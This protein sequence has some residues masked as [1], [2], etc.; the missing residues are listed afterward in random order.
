TPEPLPSV[1]PIVAARHVDSQ[2]RW[3]ARTAENRSQDDPPIVVRIGRLDV[4]AVQAP[5]A[6]RP[7]PGPRPASGPTLEERLAARDRR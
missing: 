4:R 3:T 1:E 2:Q 5:P 6:P 7:Q